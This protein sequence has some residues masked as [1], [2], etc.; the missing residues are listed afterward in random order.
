MTIK[1]LRAALTKK[2]AQQ[3]PNHKDADGSVKA[4]KPDA[5][6]GPVPKPH[7]KFTGRGR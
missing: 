7:K 6:T 1:G 5:G 2:Q 4:V 3:H